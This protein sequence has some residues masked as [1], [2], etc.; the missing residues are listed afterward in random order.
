MKE[1]QDTLAAMR[2]RARGRVKHTPTQE[3]AKIIQTAFS[4]LEFESG[5][6]II[7]TSSYAS[8]DGLAE[9]LKQRPTWSVDLKGYTDSS[10]NATKNLQLSRDRAYA[11]KAYLVNKGVPASAMQTFG[12]GADNPVASNST[13]A[14]RAKN[15]R[16][17]I[18]LFSKE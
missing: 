13:A 12:F 15:R 5:K 4:T 3:E 6:D 16:V 17:E 9:L 14:G 2:K 7:K 18:E 10:G 11:V 8:L 1:L